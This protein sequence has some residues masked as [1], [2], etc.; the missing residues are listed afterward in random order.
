MAG[1]AGKCIEYPFDTIKVR[2]QTQ[3]DH[4]VLQYKGALDC[5][6]QSIK[7][8]GIRSLYRGISAPL[9]GA[10]AESSSLF[11]FERL[12]REAIYASGLGSRY[13]GLSLPA[14][15][16]AGA[17]SGFFTSFVL[18]PIELLKCRVQASRAG[19]G[20]PVPTLRP[21]QV[22]RDVYR[23]EG[24]RGFWRGQVGTLIR[25]TGGTAAWFGAKET[26]TALFQ[27]RR[28][29]GSE[30]SDSEAQKLLS[31]PLPLWQQAVAGV[32]AGLSYNFLFF[33]ADT[34]KSRMQ[35]SLLQGHGPARSFWQE[36]AALW[37]LHGVRGMYRGCGITCLRAAPASA[38]IFMVYDG[39]KTQLG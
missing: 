11:F 28:V 22:L 16:F 8:G 15:W 27:K 13:L 5:F 20:V 12:G 9:L 17:F 18:T 23:A 29:R 31:Q 2:L 37:A 39:L 21:L 3:P 10:S 24:L 26:V 30:S 7:S 35:T 14:L 33:P 32:A 34:I 25:E 6:T 19:N 38:F 4:L 1:M 36:G